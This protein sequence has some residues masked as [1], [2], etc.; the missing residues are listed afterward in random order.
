VQA[1]V[2][3]EWLAVLAADHTVAQLELERSP[4]ATAVASAIREEPRLA[5]VAVAAA[6]LVGPVV[7]VPVTMVTVVSARNT[8][9]QA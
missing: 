5:V 7:A 8:P 1:A 4:A 3:R 6:V 9:F 2:E